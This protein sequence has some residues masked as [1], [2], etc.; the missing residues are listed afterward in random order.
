MAGELK[1]SNKICKIKKIIHH[2]LQT[3]F[4]EEVWKSRL[5]TIIKTN[6]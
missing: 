5:E 4:K 3:P 2:F 6:Q 1:V